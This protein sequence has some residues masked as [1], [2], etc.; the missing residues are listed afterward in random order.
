MIKSAFSSVIVATLAA[1]SAPAFADTSGAQAPSA[2]VPAVTQNAAPTV[3]E[4][5]VKKFVAAYTDVQDVRQDFSQKL[6]GVQDPEKAK[7][8]QQ[9]AQTKMDNAVT[10]NGLSVDEYR[11][12]AKQINENPQLL[13]MVQEELARSQQ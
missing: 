6:Q 13:S 9:K 2:Q 3:G 11:D 10:D 8:L 5:K 4:G 7:E 1:T 12:L